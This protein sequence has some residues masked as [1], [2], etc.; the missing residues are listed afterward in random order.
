MPEEALPLVITKVI[1]SPA[2]P[3][4]QALKVLVPAGV[5]Y[6][7]VHPVVVLVKVHVYPPEHELL[8]SVKVLPQLLVLTWPQVTAFTFTFVGGLLSKMLGQRF[9]PINPVFRVNT[10][11]RHNKP[12]VVKFVA[13]I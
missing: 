6:V 7:H 12:I 1:V 10:A 2:D 13:F 8:L 9:C 5:V 11:K 4:I 3:L